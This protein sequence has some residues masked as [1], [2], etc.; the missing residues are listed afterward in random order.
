[1]LV[2]VLEQ[3]WGPR[4]S[5]P[6][7][8]LGDISVA[9]RSVMKVCSL[10]L[11][12]FCSFY[13]K[14]CPPF[15]PSLFGNLRG[16]R[17]SGPSRGA[18]HAS[19]PALICSLAQP[20]CGSRSPSSVLCPPTACVVSSFQKAKDDVWDLGDFTRGPRPSIVGFLCFCVGFCTSRHQQCIL[21]FKHQFDF[22]LFLF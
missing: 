17:G 5:P 18:W 13:P 21:L 10:A 22:I 11:P 16:S 9:G 8:G 4:R 7:Q 19:S 14:T 12:V 3:V 2:G 15:Q 1:M 6:L 20:H